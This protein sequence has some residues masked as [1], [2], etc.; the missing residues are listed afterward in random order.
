MSKLSRIRDI[1][2]T[3]SYSESKSYNNDYRDSDLYRRDIDY[4]YRD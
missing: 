1:I 3:A 2:R 4:Y